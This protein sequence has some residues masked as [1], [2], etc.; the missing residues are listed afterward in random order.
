MKIMLTGSTGFVGSFIANKL[1]HSDHTLLALVRSAKGQV[2]IVGES[3]IT[4]IDSHT[5]YSHVLSGVD[6]VVHCAACTHIM[7]MDV[8]DL[9]AEYR[10]VNVDATLNLAQQAADFG[11]KRFIFVSSIKVNGEST[12]GRVPFIEKDIAKPLDPYGVSKYEAEE[13]LKKIAAFTGMEV[14]IVRPPLVYGAGVKANFLNLLK[15]SNTGSPLPFGLVNNKRSMVYVENLVDF[16]VKCIVHPAAANQTFIVSDNEDLSLRGLLQ[17]IRESMG[18]PARLIP[19]PVFLFKLAGLIFRKQYMV[20]R[21][22]GD[23]QVDSSNALSLLNWK[24]PFTVVQGIQ[25]TVDSFLE[26]NN[27]EKK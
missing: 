9:L 1:L 21:L 15:L 3:H 24:P 16:I 8:V 5:D 7:N 2:S 4:N 18:K 17:L 14:V 19:V 25:A 13:G 11:V 22:V 10:R 23:L 27:Q 6:A 26:N 20:D 12:T